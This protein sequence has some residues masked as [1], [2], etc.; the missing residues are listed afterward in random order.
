[1]ALT[2]DALAS[3]TLQNYMKKMQDNIFKQYVLL[4]YISKKCM[5]KAAHGRSKMVQ[6]MIGKN[7]T[8]KNY[9]DYEAL[10]VTPQTGMTSAEF[11][12][13]QNSAS[14]AI[15]GGEK[16]Q[17]KGTEGVIDLLTEKTKQT[18]KS[19]AEFLN[20]Q[21]LS[22]KADG[23]FGADKDFNGIDGL[24]GSAADGE[25]TSVGKIL[26]ADAPSW[27]SPQTGTTATGAGALDLAKLN[28]LYN[29]LG[30]GPDAPDIEVTTQALFE[31]YESLLLPNMRYADVKT[32]NAGFQSLTHKGVPV[33]FDSMVKTGAWYMLSSEHLK[34]T[35]VDGAW[36]SSQGF[37][38][39][40][41]KDASFALILT[42]GQLWTDSR[43]SLG[44]L[45]GLT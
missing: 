30:V 8:V 27:V 4:D 28:N 33:V 26:V 10:D 24:I 22:N 14:V 21:F 35:P 40:V 39:P 6:V 17:N 44:K 38:Q 1:M 32:A 43:R 13:A 31:K 19:I 3:T 45:V 20:G 9:K 42:H 37:R 7:S 12:W 16:R 25:A 2:Y 23:G 11:F 41:D 36:F 18:E 5:T 34:F 29:G 15:S